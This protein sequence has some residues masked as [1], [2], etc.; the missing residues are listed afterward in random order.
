MLSITYFKLAHNLGANDLYICVDPV[1]TN[2]KHHEPPIGG[3]NI[4]LSSAPIRHKNVVD[5]KLAHNLGVNGLGI[6][7]ALYTPIKNTKSH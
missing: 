3:Q 5:V 4:W 7:V 2:K 6:C 1:H